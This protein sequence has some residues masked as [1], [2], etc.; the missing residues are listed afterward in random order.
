MK[1]IKKFDCVEMKH[2]G[3]DK[4]QQQLQ[5]KT[6]HQQVSFWQQRTEELKRQKMNLSEKYALERVS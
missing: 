4:V 2:R 6:L 3:A 5:G 1:E